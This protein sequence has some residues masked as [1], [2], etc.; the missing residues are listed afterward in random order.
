M[1]PPSATPTTTG[2][3][4]PCHGADTGLG[5]ARRDEY[6]ALVSG[7]LEGVESSSVGI[8]RFMAIGAW[9]VVL[10]T[11]P[12]ADPGWFVFESTDGRNQFKD[13]W[14][15]MAVEDDRPGLVQ[16]ATALGA[17]KDFSTCFAET[18]LN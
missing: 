16:W 4:A 17:P 3:T 8:V 7:A 10:A 5:D 9:S 15:G 13:V 2:G 6:L 11:T 1:D 14:A 12:V 18:I